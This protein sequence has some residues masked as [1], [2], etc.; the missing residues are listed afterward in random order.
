[1]IGFGRCRFSPILGAEAGLSTPL[2]IF[3]QTYPWGN[4]FFCILM[5]SFNE[6]KN[7]KE[8]STDVMVVLLTPGLK[9]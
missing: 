5:T 7:K 6:N 3:P 8:W 9:T 1:M 2:K 4:N